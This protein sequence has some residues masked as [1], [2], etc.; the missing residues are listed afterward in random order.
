MF[1]VFVLVFL[2]SVRK[3]EFTLGSTLS[4]NLEGFT[5]DNDVTISLG[6]KSTENEGLILRDKQ[7]VR[8]PTYF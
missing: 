5:L 2:Q 7:Q 4:D 1:C 8:L 6:F 3:A